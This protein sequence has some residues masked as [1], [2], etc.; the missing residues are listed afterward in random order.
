MLKEIS[1]VIMELLVRNWAIRL[2]VKR[3]GT[4]GWIDAMD[5]RASGKGCWI[6]TI[7]T[8][9]G[10]VCVCSVLISMT[11]NDGDSWQLSNFHLGNGGAESL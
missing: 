10:C 4:V 6:G 7:R 11:G 5:G 8:T 2:G 1:S 9:S 3:V